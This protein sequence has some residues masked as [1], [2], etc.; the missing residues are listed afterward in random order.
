MNQLQISRALRYALA[1]HRP[2]V[3]ELRDFDAE[4]EA[5]KRYTMTN[6]ADAAALVP[7]EALTESLVPDIAS[8]SFTERMGA[9]TI[10]GLSGNIVI[11]TD[12]GGIRFYPQDTEAAQSTTESKTVFGA[13]RPHLT[14][15]TAEVPVSYAFLNTSGPGPEAVLRRIISRRFAADRDN[16]ALQGTGVDGQPMGL[17]SAPGVNVVDFTG[18]TYTSASQTI[19]SLLDDFFWLA[20]DNGE[21]GSSRWGYAGEPPVGRK[22]SRVKST[23]GRDVLFPFGKRELMENAVTWT[24]L[25]RANLA[26][27][28]TTNAGLFFG[29]WSR[30]LHMLFGALEIRI[31]ESGDDAKRGRARF[32]LRA[33][34]S[35]VLERP[36]AFSR[37]A[38][39]TVA[40]S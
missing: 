18:A 1:Q 14:V 16:Y 2:G 20:V 17:A 8:E 23:T 13:L 35:L 4:Q 19:T 11:P 3:V 15:L 40:L 32:L 7:F 37:A 39:F 24:R 27:A 5:H 30:M 22:L 12:E 36:E 33:P 9:R 21:L 34:Y 10:A 31:V 25:A 26:A 38:A 28:G 6:V 29:D